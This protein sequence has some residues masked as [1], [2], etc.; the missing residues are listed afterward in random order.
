MQSRV[1]TPADVPAIADL[2]RRWEAA[3]FGAP[4]QDEHE[5]RENFDRAEGSRVLVEA[6]RMVAAAWRWGT[7]TMLVVDPDVALEPI[8]ADLLA[9]LA[10]RPGTT[11]SALSRDQAFRS[12]LE[13]RGWRH[14]NSAFELSRAFT[15]D[16]VIAEPVWP[17]GVAVRAYRDE[18]A[19]SVHRL[20][21]VDSGWAEIAGHHERDFEQWRGIFANKHTVPAQQVLAWRGER[22]VGIAM[23]R[24]FA[25]G[26]GWVS[27]LA[28][29]K[30][31]RGHG[32]GR[33]LLLEALRRRRDGGATS[34]GLGVSE[35]NRGALEL[36]LRVG[37]EIKRE[38]MEYACP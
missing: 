2:E 10:E 9:W 4:E 8:Y 20:I 34:V 18:D 37:L 23:G 38:W 36:Y 28:V 25:D 35:V 12:A 29:A 22:L 15:P 26:T 6:D 5:V 17:E 30:D 27:Q 14:A 31:E 1:A 16:W 32:L 21:Y 33:A 19:P 7:E 11:A 24:T 3:W 13:D